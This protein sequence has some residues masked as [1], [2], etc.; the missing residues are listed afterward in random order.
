MNRF[1]GFD[2]FRQLRLSV[3]DDVTFIEDAVVPVDL[4]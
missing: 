1:E 3:L 2:R 4:R